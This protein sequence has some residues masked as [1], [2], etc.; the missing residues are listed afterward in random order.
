M[1]FFEDL[2][3]T[4]EDILD[5]FVDVVDELIDDIMDEVRRVY[6]EIL[7]WLT[8]RLQR[9]V[10]KLTGFV[11]GFIARLDR[12]GLRG[13]VIFITARIIAFFS[14]DKL[15]AA[16]KNAFRKPLHELSDSELGKLSRSALSGAI[17]A[18]RKV[19]P[20]L[21]HAER[22]QIGDGQLIH[23]RA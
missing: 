19:K 23:R 22:Q 14:N 21:S 16:A 8:A 5:D 4:I 9:I 11:S 17:E 15:A 20:D 13:G 2:A 6:R 3:V 7:A 1:G 18:T 10:E 12:D